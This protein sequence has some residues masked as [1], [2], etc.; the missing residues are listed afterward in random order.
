M[1][2][3]RRAARRDAV[4]GVTLVVPCRALAACA[5]CRARFR[6]SV[7]TRAGRAFAPPVCLV[8]RGRGD[9]FAAARL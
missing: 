1:T 5:L 9:P 7:G 6:A 4:G 3:A 2:L 8:P